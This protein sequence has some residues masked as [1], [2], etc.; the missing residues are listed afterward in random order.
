[1]ATY[2]G[3]LLDEVWDDVDDADEVINV[4]DDEDEDYMYGSSSWETS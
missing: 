1:M 3:G 2:H 4:D